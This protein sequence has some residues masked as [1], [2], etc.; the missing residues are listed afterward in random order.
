MQPAL[1]GGISGAIVFAVAVGFF[2]LRYRGLSAQQGGIQRERGEGGQCA[3][4]LRDFG[5]SCSD[6][7]ASQQRELAMS[8][9]DRQRKHL[10]SQAAAISSLLVVL[11]G[12]LAFNVAES[13]LARRQSKPTVEVIAEGASHH[14]DIPTEGLT[15]VQALTAGQ[16]SS[17]A[18]DI[19]SPTLIALRRT[20]KR[21][22]PHVF[23][24][25]LAMVM[26]G[27]SGATALQPGDIAQTVGWETTGLGVQQSTEPGVAFEVAGY[28]E[29]PG[30]FKTVEVSESIM[31]VTTDEYAGSFEVGGVPADVVI[32]TRK[33]PGGAPL[34][35]YFIPIAE[36]YLNFT[37]LQS[38]IYVGDQL[39]YALLKD[40]P[41]FRND[42]ASSR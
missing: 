4:F 24:L 41:L 9:V 3:R 42:D 16:S 13:R 26:T 25:P 5:V 20:D 33:S 36:P 21:S 28:V 37:L 17:L 38:R 29:R 10:P 7:T 40:V 6:L 31:N 12:L 22:T 19:D 18:D 32:V 1:I 35:H 11:V 39:E 15:L 14:V 2:I 8:V 23:Y 34:E 27:I 30:Q